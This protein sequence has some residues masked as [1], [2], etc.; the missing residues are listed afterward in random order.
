MTRNDLQNSRAVDV[1]I[2]GMAAKFPGA[3]S[4]DQFWAN[5]RDGV[6]SIRR[7]SDEELLAA[8]VPAA[9]LAD[10]DY[11]KASPVLDN[12]D[13]FDAAFFGLSARDAS[14]MD[15]AHR[16]FL[17]IA[18]KAFEHAGYTALPEEGAVGVFA[19]AGAPIYMMENLRTNPDLMRSMGEFLVRH[20][21]NDMNFLAT[22]VSY[23]M[24]LRGPSMNVQTAC[25]SSLVAVHLAC[26]S[27]ARGECTMALA[28]GAT[29]L[30]PQARGYHFK[31]GEILSPDGHC[32]P[33]DAKS[34]GTVFGSGAGAIILKRLS[35]ALDDGDTIHAVI[36]GSA[37][38]NDGAVKVSYLAPGVQGQAAVIV[39]ALASA[40][41]EADSI[42][43]IETHGTGTLVGDPIEVEALRE[44][45]GP[46]T[47]RRNYCGIGSVKSN[48]GHL[49]EAAGAASLIKAVMALKHRKLPPSLGFET[50]NPAI[51]FANSPFYVNA[52]LNDW[53]SD[54][55]LRCGVTALGAGG[56]NCHLILEEAPAGIPGEGE[57]SQQ[58]IVLSAKSR[59]ALDARSLN[60]ADALEA[61]PD[62]DLADTSY[63]LAIGR[64]SLPHRRVF[65]ATTAGEAARLLRGEDAKRVVTGLAGDQTPKT[66]FMFPGG[67]AQYAGMGRELYETEE[68]YR[69]AITDCLDI[70]G[71]ALDVDLRKLMYPE[72]TDTEKSTRALER[73]SFTLPSLFATEYALGRLFM[74]WGVTPQAFIGH[75][76]GEYAAACLAGVMSLEDTLKLV[77]MRGRLFEVVQRGSM[78]SVQLSESDLRAI[79]PKGLDIA[80]ANAPE[81]SV[82]SG[83]VQAIKDLQALL[84]S[85]DIE[86][87]PVHIDV[88]AHSS[89]LDPVLDQFRQL[90]RTISFQLPKTPFVSNVT[91]KWI[92]AEQATSPEYWVTHLRSTVRFADGLATLRELG[93][94]VLLETG[95]GRTLSMLARAQ[96]QPFQNAFSSLRHPQESASDLG[97]ALTS[98]GRLWAV[99]AEVD[100]S[101]FYDGQL[102][103]RIPLPTYPF[104]HQ[105]YWVEPGKNLAIAPIAGVMRKADVTDWFSTIGYQE[106]PLVLRPEAARQRIWL[107][108]AEKL[109]DARDL[110]IAL[111]PHRVVIATPGSKFGERLDGTFSMN[112]GSP[113]DHASIMQFMEESVGLPDHVVFLTNRRAGVMSSED[114]ILRRFLPMIHLFQALGASSTPAQVSI[115]ASGIA[116]V[117]GSPL[118]P[119][120]A[121]MLGPMLVA[122]REFD[123]LHTRCIDV[124]ADK[125]APADKKR[126]TVRI[127]NELRAE[128]RDAIVAL[129]PASR[130]VRQTTSRQLPASEA[131]A[132]EWARE[133]GVYFITGGLG[134]IGLE[135]ATHMARSKRVRLALLA[136]EQ[137]PSEDKWDSIL[138]KSPSSRVAERIAKVRELRA[139]GARVMVLAGDVT[140][141]NALAAALTSVRA[142]FG[143][144]NGVIHA[145]GVMDDAPMMTKTSDAIR[146]V[147]SPKVDGT[148]ALDAIVTETL[149][150]MML[151]SSVASSLGL[152]GQADYTAA[153]AFQDA[154]ARARSTRAGGRT[155]VVN[156]N[157][158]RDVGMA[159]SAHRRDTTGIE[160]SRPSRH[161]AL[162]GYSE[163][164]AERTFVATFA[165]EAAWLLNEHVTKTGIALLPGTGFVELARAAYAEDRRNQPVEL[166]NLEFI[167]P[168]RKEADKA[169]RLEITLTPSGEASDFVMRAGGPNSSPIAM[170][171]AQLC[172]EQQPARLDIASIAARCAQRDEASS[173]GRLVQDFMAFGPRWANIQRTRYGQNEA[174]IELNLDAAFVNDLGDYVLHPAMLDMATG[175]AQALIPGVDLSRDFYVPLGYER[176]RVFGAMPAHVFSHVRC[177]ADASTGLAYFDITLT[178]EP[179]NVFADIA[180]FTMRRVDG[181]TAFAAVAARAAPTQRQD[182]LIEALRDGIRSAE[183]VDALDRIMAQ[184]GL[185]QVIASSVDVNAWSA[186]LD[187]TRIQTTINEGSV[188]G[189]ERLPG[190]PEYVAPTTGAERVLAAIW[191]E[192]LGFKAVGVTDNFFDLGGNSLLGVRLFAGIRKKFSVSLPLAT[193]FEAQTI[194]DL[195]KL[196][197][198]PS[199]DIPAAGD[200]A[201]SPLVCLRPGVAGQTPVFF[202]HGSRGNVLVFKSFA[203]RVR[204]E[205]PV[206]AL[207]AAG[208]DGKMEPDQTIEVMAERYLRAIRQ[209]QPT[210][211]YMF[212]GYSGGGVIGY[213]MARRLREEGQETSMLMLIDTLE[214]EQMRRPVSMP[215]H[216]KNLHRVK[217][218]RFL[219][220]P[221]VLW[222]Y[223]FRP[224]LRKLMGVPDL[225]V[226]RTPL[227]AASD[228]VDRAY[229]NA[230]WAYQTP[231]SE[232]DVVVIRATDARMHFLRSGPALGWD[233]FVSGKIKTFDVDAEHD[234]VFAEPSLSQLIDA[235]EICVSGE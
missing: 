198:D 73:P 129:A 149:D 49:G 153:N 173:D 116:G 87:T 45:F 203:D 169:Q 88:A 148:L 206:Y 111:S 69:E 132:A 188:E 183:G 224:M 193:L 211:P 67:G 234:L 166:S 178:D 70:V 217:L 171:R 97:F 35:D 177:T 14:V 3:D 180:R 130:W 6:E 62:V 114:A 10:P 208:V 199:Q 102:R 131:G 112:F 115:V 26:Q 38:N 54:D 15:P 142:A 83:P 59:A 127:A 5:V 147:L 225:P 25:S 216:L 233:R 191:A 174:L 126:L 108:I 135:V 66:V 42:S 117:G 58:L 128:T 165:G 163:T 223:K 231:R 63:T 98:L 85:R 146:R 1:A 56:T 76:V 39:S 186:K 151:F 33:F 9:T 89:M 205:Q 152:P 157:A 99:G 230:Q 176:V 32:R 124:P 55:P 123:H 30:L 7:L 212:A 37:I 144:L 109:S 47:A 215:D 22:R 214:P 90:C 50:P 140:D 187:A 179:G 29:V 20:T 23:E 27:L 200:A 2:I 207:Q 133:D 227:E 164:G 196:L 34:A 235:F 160:P 24:D 118:Q 43:Y 86:S 150:F 119:T 13:K 8:G 168:F 4:I 202:I 107:C 110:A 51:D 145:A 221:H 46:Q 103:N 78:L 80:A 170:G 77:M 120:Q 184:P 185:V 61:N 81:L 139:L 21:G 79:M 64:R 82:A 105:S 161:P 71:P 52:R 189:F 181:A 137:L 121:L 72:V 138:A 162:D 122:P 84:A 220:L 40:G 94:V 141:R 60:L 229:K 74:S 31:E 68:V 219:E 48:I 11:V 192:L 158:W 18:W 228:D 75:S 44:A 65:A 16:I 12:I 232:L 172:R 143:P 134:G 167:A 201:W 226:V 195:A 154:F 204:A 36:R 155:V 159:A 197:A 156:W 113:E 96:A 91:G 125:L 93:E 106:A 190:L 175:G 41:L 222:K 101:A 194:A 213:E 218:H 57:R 100:W 210:G 92:T 209:V 53:A 104:E 17:E 136:R 182:A 28:G 19:A 95:P